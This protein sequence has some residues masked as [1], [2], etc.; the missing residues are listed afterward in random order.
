MPQGGKSADTAKEKRQ[1]GAI[2]KGQKSV[3]RPGA[4]AR[5]FAP[6][7]Q[8][9]GGGKNNGSGRKVPFGPVGGSGRKTNLARSS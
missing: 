3:G 7:T 5:A 2:K 4:E 9:Q 8:H 6:V 1:V